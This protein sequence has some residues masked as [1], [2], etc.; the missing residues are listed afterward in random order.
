MKAILVVLLILVSFT[1]PV[2]S[3]AN[4]IDTT[5]YNKLIDI[6]LRD[7]LFR[8]SYLLCFQMRTENKKIINI[9]VDN[10]QLWRFFQ[11]EGLDFAYY[12]HYMTK[13]LK[14]KMIFNRLSFN[15]KENFAYI[16]C[17]PFRR[18]QKVLKKGIEATKNYITERSHHNTADVH[19]LGD[20]VYQFWEWGI[21]MRISE[22]G[23]PF[24]GFSCTR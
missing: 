22:Y 8:G 17:A 20:I 19:Y 23:V 16:D 18:N 12:Y 21:G 7:T 6:A 15:I 9:A 13:I 1:V 11:T 5:C 10:F 2:K 24:V 14:R 4:E 3:S